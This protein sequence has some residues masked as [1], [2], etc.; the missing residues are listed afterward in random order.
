M[1][2]SYLILKLF[3]IG[4]DTQFSWSDVRKG[5]EAEDDDRS[6]DWTVQWWKGQ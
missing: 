5:T 3:K 4:I 6:S 2:Q 1:I